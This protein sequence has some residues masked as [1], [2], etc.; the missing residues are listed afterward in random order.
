MKSKPIHEEMSEKMSINACPG[1]TR[2]KEPVP[3][4][5]ECP[6]CHAEV[7]IW[8]NEYSRSCQNCGSEVLKDEVPTCIEWCDFGKE[9]VGEK[10]YNRY[11][12]TKGK[13]IEERSQEDEEKIKEYFD[14]VK[15]LCQKW[16]EMHG[17]KT[18]NK[19]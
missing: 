15:N 5:F 8:S 4:L 16:S 11:M 1:S 12:E 14:K 3:E 9:C 7:E 13:N 10:A 18:N 17:K 19:D 2:I 6:K